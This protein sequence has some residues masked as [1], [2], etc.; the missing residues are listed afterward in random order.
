M[1]LDA[2]VF[3]NARNLDLGLNHETLHVDEATGGCTWMTLLKVS[4]PPQVP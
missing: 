2:V 1:G 4:G 3:K